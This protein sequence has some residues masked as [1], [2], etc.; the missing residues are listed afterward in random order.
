M[1]LIGISA[2]VVALDQFTKFMVLQSLHLNESVPFLT[3]LLYFTY[4]QNP[5]TAFGFM[6]NMETLIRIPFFIAITSAAGF[7]VHTYQR[8]IPQDKILSR[9]A[10]GLVWGGALGNLIDRLL[11]GKVIDFIDVRYQWFPYIFNVADSCVTIGVLCLLF[12]F[13]KEETGKTRA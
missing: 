5:G 2:L 10:L 8:F 3:G 13:L 9:I 12:E 6:S 11:Y 1:M 7:I 4:I